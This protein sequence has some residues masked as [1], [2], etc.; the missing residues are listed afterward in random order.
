LYFSSFLLILLTF[1]ST[2]QTISQTYALG[3][4]RRLLV[5][6]ISGSLASYFFS[7]ALTA[8]KKQPVTDNEKQAN[9]GNIGNLMD[10]KTDRLV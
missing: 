2:D 8:Q 4:Q 9:R 7:I 10:E 3:G 6:F 5:I 1:P